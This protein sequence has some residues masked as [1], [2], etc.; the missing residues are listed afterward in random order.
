MTRKK[1]RTQDCTSAQAHQRL[2]HAE[3]FL[4]VADLTADEEGD[5]GIGYG[6]VAASLAVLAGIAASDAAC[7]H[8]LGKRSRSPDHRDAEA[9]LKQIAPGGPS[10]AGNLRKLLDLKDTAHYGLISVSRPELRRA[11]RQAK[12]LVDFA[13]EIAQR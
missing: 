5:P 2:A 8:A 6:S 3:S 1:G 9:L 12:L 4:E 11:M 13:A 7:C 10:A